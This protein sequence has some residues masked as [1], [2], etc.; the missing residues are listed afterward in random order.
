M[1]TSAA[2][3]KYEE[4][5]IP[6][7]V[8]VKRDGEKM[9]P[10]ARAHEALPESAPMSAEGRAFFEARMEARKKAMDLLPAV[11]QFAIECTRAGADFDIRERFDELTL[12]IMAQAREGIHQV[13]SHQGQGGAS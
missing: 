2:R 3:E 9:T 8:R 4:M 10:E 7:F 13:P 5:G 12:D 11:F 1:Y 6:S